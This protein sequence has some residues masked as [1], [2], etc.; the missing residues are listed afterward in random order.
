MHGR[1]VGAGQGR[2]PTTGSHPQPWGS[3]GWTFRACSLGLEVRQR[4]I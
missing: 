3:A 2:E 1:R 4:H